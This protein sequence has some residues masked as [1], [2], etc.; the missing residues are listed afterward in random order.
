ML[1]L[2]IGFAL[3]Y[4]VALNKEKAQEYWNKLII[5]ISE[6]Y[7]SIKNKQDEKSV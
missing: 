7:K 2:I 6:K 1:K 3:G 4:W 5:Y